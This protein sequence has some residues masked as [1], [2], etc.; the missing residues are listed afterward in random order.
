MAKRRKSK[1]K[2]PNVVYV[3]ITLLIAFSAYWGNENLSNNEIENIVSE[4]RIV[5]TQLENEDLKI[6]YLNVGQADSILI[7]NQNKNMLIDAGNNGDGDN[8][9]KYLKELQ[10]NKIDILVGTHPHEDHIGGLDDII[11]SFEI[12][13][14]YMPKVATTTKTFEDVLDAI[15]SK[16]LKVT[17]PEI[18]SEFSLG[19]LK[20]KILWTS[21]D[22]DNLNSSSIVLK[23]TFDELSYIFAGDAEAAEEKEIIKS[24]YN[25]EAQVLKLGHHGSSTSSSEEFWDKVSPSIAI[26]MTGE[27]NSY[28]HPHKEVLERLEARNIKVY[29]T[30]TDGTILITSDGKS[31]K[32]EVLS[33]IN[34]DG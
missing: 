16:E 10:I 4:T 34:L 11:N 21:D 14:I 9:V 18:D 25:I 17:T 27:G 22:E 12:G 30:D 29:R 23:M 33:E 8:I 19:D 1:N 32:V 7:Q 20:F 28:G 31:N 2:V 15:E 6:Y 3:L 13:T 26:I 5:Q 24:G